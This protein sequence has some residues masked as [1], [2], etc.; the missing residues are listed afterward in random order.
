M[1]TKIVDN[2][3]WYQKADVFSPDTVHQVLVFGSFEDLKKLKADIGQEKIRQIF[4]ERP[5]KFYTGPEFNF[6][7]NYVLKIKETLDESK[8]LK[9]TPRN[10][11][12]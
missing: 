10:I 4:I 7:K 11:G 5:K 12:F 9:D 1:K 8:Y 2:L 6:I 3:V